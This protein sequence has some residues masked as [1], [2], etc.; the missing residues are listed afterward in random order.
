M[1]TGDNVTSDLYSV[2][3][4]NLLLLKSA[5][6]EASLR[7]APTEKSLGSM[8]TNSLINNNLFP[9]HLAKATF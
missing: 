5:T 4:K 7:I 1:A 3:L 8:T 9:G 6:L 2:F